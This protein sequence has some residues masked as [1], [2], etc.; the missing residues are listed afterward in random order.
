M[1]PRA[2]NSP[3]VDIFVVRARCWF[4]VCYVCTVYSVSFETSGS[5]G[6]GTWGTPQEYLREY[7]QALRYSLHIGFANRLLVGRARGG[8]AHLGRTHVYMYTCTHTYTCYNYTCTHTHHIH[9]TYMYTYISH[10]HT[11]I[12]VHIHIIYMIHVHIHVHVHIIYMYTH[13]YTCIH[14]HECMETCTH[15]QVHTCT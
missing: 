8:G 7:H 6:S 2:Q 5:P 1:K 10:T 15:I 12:H 14:M 4:I 11:Y 9:Y 3:R 13:T